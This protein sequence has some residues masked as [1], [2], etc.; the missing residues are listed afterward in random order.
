MKT[1]I[2]TLISFQDMIF[3]TFDY[4]YHNGFVLFADLKLEL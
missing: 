2:N 1:S 4:N 3:N